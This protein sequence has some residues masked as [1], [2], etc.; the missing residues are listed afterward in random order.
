MTATAA[1]RIA[2]PDVVAAAPAVIGTEGVGGGAGSPRRGGGGP[3]GHRV[4]R[5]S[6][7]ARVVPDVVAAAPAVIGIEG[8][9]GTPGRLRRGV[10]S[11]VG[12]PIPGAV[13]GC[14]VTAAAEDFSPPSIT[15]LGLWL[16]AT[17][18]TGLAEG[19]PVTTWPDLS[20]SGFTATW[21]A[22]SASP[23]V[24]QAAS[25]NGLPAVNFT[26]TQTTAQTYRVPGWGTAV[27]GKTEYTLLM[28]ALTHEL[29]SGQVPV[30]FTGPYRAERLDLAGR[31]TTR[32]AAC[33]GGTAVTADMTASSP[34]AWVAC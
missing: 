33:S 25:F 24:Y 6:A 2:F 21:D 8:V 3:R 5:A 12:L 34:P 17:Q 10:S 13:P 26:A 28:V 27:S 18:I 23:P 20:P 32:T 9:G 14:R 30:I 15:G 1:A 7:A 11:A 29:V 4:S 16:D 22:A 19:E 31:S